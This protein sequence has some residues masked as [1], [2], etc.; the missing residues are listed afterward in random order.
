MEDATHG[1][2][3]GGPNH[4]RVAKNDCGC[5]YELDVDPDTYLATTMKGLIC[6]KLSDPADPDNKCDVNTIANPDNVASM[7]GHKMLLIAE[8]TTYH[9]NNILWLYDLE[10]REL[11][12]ELVQHLILQKSARRTSILMWEGSHTSQWSCSIPI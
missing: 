10:K 8:D 5:V 11:A 9:Y 1:N 12:D 7:H 4:I 6:G 2:D 3:K